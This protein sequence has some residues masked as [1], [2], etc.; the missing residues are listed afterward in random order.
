MFELENKTNIMILTND[1]LKK[2]VSNLSDSVL[3]EEKQ[4]ADIDG[5]Q[6][7][8]SLE[9]P[10]DDSVVINIKVADNSDRKKLDSFIS[11]FNNS[12][13]SLITDNF[14]KLTGKPLEY[15]NTLYAKGKY[16]EVKDLLTTT[17]QKSIQE[18]TDIMK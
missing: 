6:V 1:F 15:V 13:F 9:K 4:S 17:L 14:E 11:K 7:V 16:K 5:K 3:Y 18:L 8:A 12:Q 10:T 2:I